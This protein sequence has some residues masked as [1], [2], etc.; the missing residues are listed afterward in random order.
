MSNRRTHPP[1][2]G[3]VVVI[4]GGFGGLRLARA[5]STRAARR[6]GVR[7]TLIDRHNHH[8]FQP[9]LYQVA[10][11]GLQP[12]DIG[13][14]LRAALRRR[15]VALRMG[16]VVDIDP[17]RRTVHLADGGWVGYDR[18]VLAVGAIADDFGVPGVAEH[19]YGLKTLADATTL[20]NAVLGRF[21]AA[22]AARAAGWGPSPDMTFVVAGGGPTGVELAGALAEL[23]D[24]VVRHDHP[25]LE[26]SNVRILL[27][28]PRD[29]LLGA[30]STASSEHARA[31]LER[32]GVEV[33]LGVGVAR[34]AADHV[35]LTDGEVVATR[36]LVWAAGV[37]AS[38][39][40]AAL[41]APLTT[42]RRVAVDE[43]LQ[44]VGCDDV[45]AIGDVAGFHVEDGGVLPQVAPVAMQQA[46]HVAR[47]ILHGPGSEG[48]RYRD[49]GSM[50]TIGRA[51]AVA[52][53]PGRIRLRGM[54]GWVA[55]LALHLLQ[56]VGFK[57]RLGVLVSWIWN[58]VTVDHAARLILDQREAERVETGTGWVRR[59]W[60]A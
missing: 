12:Q 35:Q 53:L 28:E 9:L 8:T 10:T 31:Q 39:V 22:S 15:G 44:V 13:I 3:H 2:G 41:G 21:E 54:L 16:E 47:T 60:A 1:A 25:D 50:A 14:S 29:R 52:E 40:A 27:I 42:G 48:F 4:G 37:A 51:A 23:V 11:A 20:R 6:A 43:H 56:L 57:N 19:A 32:R 7:V 45:F 58:Y 33:R 46:D 5:L 30:F 18:L 49:K 17:F 26:M 55:W 34:A 24:L 59:R 36:T 38:P